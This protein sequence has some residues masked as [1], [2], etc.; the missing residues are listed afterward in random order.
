MA[1]EQ[2]RQQYTCKGQITM[3]MQYDKLQ[4][5]PIT[6]ERHLPTIEIKDK[7]KFR[8][9]EKHMLVPG[10]LRTEVDWFDNL[11]SMQVHDQCP[12]TPVSQIGGQGELLYFLQHNNKS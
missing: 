5:N 3:K 2:I 9:F 12:I 11:R 4:N 8:L 10:F 1:D 6:L 7:T